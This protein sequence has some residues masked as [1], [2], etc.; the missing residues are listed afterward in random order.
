MQKIPDMELIVKTA[1]ASAIDHGHQ[2][3]MMLVHGKKQG[4]MV[5]FG[6]IPENHK[7]KMELMLK[8]GVAV[9][10]HKETFGELVSVYFI[11][12]AWASG[13]QGEPPKDFVRPSLDPDRKEILL[14]MGKRLDTDENEFGAF[15]MI[16][17]KEGKLVDFKDYAADKG[18]ITKSESPLLDAFLF[19]YKKAVPVPPKIVATA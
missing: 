4:T 10:E 11:S 13:F 7:D 3:P 18:K 19:G 8:T 15:E 6:N 2:D 5:G 9:G 17:D 14:V 16:K 1:K 12:E